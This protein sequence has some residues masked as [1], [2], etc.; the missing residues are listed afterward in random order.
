M[1]LTVGGLAFDS[2]QLTQI[3]KPDKHWQRWLEEEQTSFLLSCLRAPYWLTDLLQER[4][5]QCSLVARWGHMILLLARYFFWRMDFLPHSCWI[6]CACLILCSLIFS[7]HLPS[8]VF[9]TLFLLK[10]TLP[11]LLLHEWGY[12]W[13]FWLPISLECWPTSSPNLPIAFGN[14]TETWDQVLYNGLP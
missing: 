13:L 4:S 5:C 12:Y 10:L 11:C 3:H 6:T 9:C 14:A 1:T 7:V 2:L 8:P